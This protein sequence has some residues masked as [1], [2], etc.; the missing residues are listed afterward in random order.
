MVTK[1]QSQK[2]Y[3][4]RLTEAFKEPSGSCPLGCLVAYCLITCQQAW[5]VLAKLWRWLL[6]KGLFFAWHAIVK[7][8]AL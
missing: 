4:Q 6:G 8:K 7:G 3:G 5:A 2:A 1:G